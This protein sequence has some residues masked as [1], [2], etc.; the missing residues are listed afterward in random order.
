MRGWGVM[1]IMVC[2]VVRAFFFMDFERLVV[3][4]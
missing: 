3:G 1:K 2:T 4:Y